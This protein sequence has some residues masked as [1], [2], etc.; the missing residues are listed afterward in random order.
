[1]TVLV[2]PASPSDLDALTGL[3]EGYLAFYDVEVARPRAHAYLAGHLEDGTASVLVGALAEDPGTLV[4]FA[5]SYPTWDSLALA[6]RWILHDLFVA[7][8]AR[9]HGVGRALLR[10]VIA[11]ATAAG[12]AGVSLETANDNLGAQGLYESEGFEHD[13]VYRT[14][15]HDLGGGAS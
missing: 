8:S 5:Q 4:G 12:A 13:R 9:R 3:F 6:P 15:V 11:A 7:P 1:M 14:Y 2:R 10:A